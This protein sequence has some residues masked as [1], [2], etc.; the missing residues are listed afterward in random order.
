LPIELNVEKKHGKNS[1]LVKN[2]E[3]FQNA[4]KEYAESQINNQA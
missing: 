1:D 2:K 3:T 4:C